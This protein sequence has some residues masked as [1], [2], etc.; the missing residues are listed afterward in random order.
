MQFFE[1]FLC[2]GFGFFSF[3]QMFIIFV[4]GILLFKLEY[5]KKLDWVCYPNYVSIASDYYL[6]KCYFE[7]FRSLDLFV[8]EHHCS[9]SLHLKK[10]H[11][12]QSFHPHLDKFWNFIFQQRWSD[13][14]CNL[15]HW[16]KSYE[17]HLHWDPQ[18]IAQM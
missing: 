6:V 17:N 2:L 11:L 4:I 14:N 10:T 5:M 18:G 8:A 12:N 9:T 16:Q 15:F 13:L 1:S 3:S 7:F